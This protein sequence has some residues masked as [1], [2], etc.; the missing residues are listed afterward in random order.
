MSKIHPLI[1]ELIDIRKEY[2]I[3][4]YTLTK[5]LG[6][7]VSP[8]SIKEWESGRRSPSL[9]SFELWAR[10]LGYEIDLHRI[11]NPIDHVTGEEYHV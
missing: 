4:P 6:D 8:D 3:P 2:R 11:S 10:T 5:M 7:N 1:Q 9:A